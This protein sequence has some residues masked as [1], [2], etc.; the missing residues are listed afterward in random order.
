MASINF[1]KHWD[2]MGSRIKEKRWREALD[3]AYQEIEGGALDWGVEI[4]VIYG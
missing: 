2:C 3:W 4:A 1:Q